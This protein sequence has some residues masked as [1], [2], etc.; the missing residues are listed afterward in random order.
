MKSF[1]CF[2]IAN[3]LTASSVTMAQ[4]LINGDSTYHSLQVYE[5]TLA[6]VIEQLGSPSYQKET[7][8]TRNSKYSD[9]TCVTSTFV[10]GYALYYRKNKVAIYVNKKHNWVEEIH[11][12]YLSPINSAKGI[13]TRKSSFA[14][15][16]SNYGNIDFDKKRQCFSQTSTRI[17]RQEM[18]Y[19][20]DVS[21]NQLRELWQE[22]TSRKFGPAQG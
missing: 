16:L 12:E 17:R 5:S 3:I 14:D 15:V 1:F 6:N 13:R 20:I 19:Q 8:G 11:F 21:W 22:A 10:Y 18:V 9:G 7:M 2:C 4:S